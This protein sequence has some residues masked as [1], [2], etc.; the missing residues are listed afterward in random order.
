MREP[1][2][3]IEVSD[4]VDVRARAA[5]LG[6]T[7]PE[8]LAILPSNF[9]SAAEAGELVLASTASTVK[10]LWR[11]KGI[12]ETPVE[13]PGKKIPFSSEKAVDWIGPVIF[14]SAA[15]L[16]ENPAAVQVALGVIANHVTDAFRGLAGWRRVKLEVVYETR[17]QN[18]FQK[19]H[20]E[21]DVDGLLQL[22]NVIRQMSD[23]A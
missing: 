20:Y 19:I 6:L 10:K 11:E 22:P 2:P 17:D 15:L 7:P 21:G 9:D 13:Q 23:D 1:Q 8:G 14:I 18:N 5:A 4:F 12:Q 16:S 3:V